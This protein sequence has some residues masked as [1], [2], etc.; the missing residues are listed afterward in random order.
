MCVLGREA[1]CASFIGVSSHVSVGSKVGYR[2][3][4]SGAERKNTASSQH[5]LHGSSPK[6]RSDPK[7]QLQAFFKQGPEE[8]HPGGLRAG[9]KE[10]GHCLLPID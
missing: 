5:V 2:G 4:D 1:V 3:Q 9:H 10:R 8:L 6:A 7:H